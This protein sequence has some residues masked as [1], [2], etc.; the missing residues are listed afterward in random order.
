MTCTNF[1]AEVEAISAAVSHV[2]T[3]EDTVHDIVILTDSLSALQALTVRDADASVRG[4][5][6]SLQRLS[7]HRTVVLQWI[8]AHCGIPGNSGWCERPE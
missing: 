2:D 3:Q 4:L 1:R 7:I 5:Q 6:D 8:A